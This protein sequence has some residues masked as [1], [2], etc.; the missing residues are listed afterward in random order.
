MKSQARPEALPLDPAGVRS[1]PRSSGRAS[2]R[3]RLAAA[4]IQDAAR[5]ARWLAE[6]ADPTVFAERIARRAAHEP[7]AYI[8]GDAP[9]WTLSLA[10]S[11]ATLIPR[12]DS[13]TL[14]IAALDA[15]PN[16]ASVRRLL[17][18]GTGT[19][20]LLLAALTEF[21]AAFG[22]GTDLAHDACRLARSNAVRTGLHDRCA[23]VCADWA[24]PVAGQFD[25]VL[26]NPP[27]IP[28]QEIDGLMPEVALH[29]PRL[30]LDGGHDGMACYRALVAGLDPL[31]APGGI[32][33]FETGAG[34]AGPVSDHAI[35]A[36]WSVAIRHDSGGHARAL[37]LSRAGG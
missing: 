18:L 24:A 1:S 3:A 11:P 33:I 9:F 25:L 19:G 5:E 31:L 30:A 23:I 20:C 34:Q 8:L 16:R 36:G 15:R 27:Y 2:G 22:V 4:G 28:R 21:P 14:I 37:I 26:S 12:A 17:D 32:A 10:V 13:E 29:E 35:E 7:L 6:G